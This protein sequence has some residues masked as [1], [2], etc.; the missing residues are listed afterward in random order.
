MVKEQRRLRGANEL[1]DLAGQFAVG[2]AYA[3]DI[4]CH[5]TSPDKWLAEELGLRYS[6]R[7]SR[8]T[9]ITDNI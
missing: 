3:F 9:T 2:N 1:G 6:V 7:N 4:Q 5:V 8:N